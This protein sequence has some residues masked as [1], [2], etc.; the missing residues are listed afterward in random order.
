MPS[1]DASERQREEFTNAGY[2]QESS[3][4]DPNPQSSVSQEGGIQQKSGDAEG[5]KPLQQADGTIAASGKSVEQEVR[6]PPTTKRIFSV[7]Q[8]LTA[9]FGSFAHGGNDVR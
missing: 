7:L 1:S 8:V 6:D 9:I 4:P 5:G 2:A 3:Q